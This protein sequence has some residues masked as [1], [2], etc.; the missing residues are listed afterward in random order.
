MK[1]LKLTL[2]DDYIKVQDLYKPF[3]GFS[4]NNI[5]KKISWEVKII[6]N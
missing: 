3:Y 5:A 1:I 2:N 4:S 6:K